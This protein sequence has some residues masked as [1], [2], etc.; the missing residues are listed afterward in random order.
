MH[1]QCVP[2]DSRDHIIFIF[3]SKFCRPHIPTD[4][5]IRIHPSDQEFPVG[6]QAT[7]FV[8]LIHPLQMIAIHINKINNN[9][10]QYAIVSD[11]LV[12][13]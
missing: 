7:I 8:A 11:I 10:V 2:D 3:G 5:I 4:A 6:C 13:V 9:L 12:F 1:T